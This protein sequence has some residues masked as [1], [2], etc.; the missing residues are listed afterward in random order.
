V[1]IFS[2]ITWH[3]LP[4]NPVNG[5]LGENVTLE[6]NFTLNSA[7]ETLDYF[8]LSRGDDKMIKYSDHTGV[9]WYKSGKGSV[10]LT[11]NGT[12]S[13]TL[14]NLKRSDEKRYCCEVNTKSKWGSEGD[15]EKSCTELLLL[16]KTWGHLSLLHLLRFSFKA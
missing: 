12:S 5:I 2:A 10:G 9:V 13:F 15:F 7:K 4:P 3:K 1:L 16:G 14:I 11:R 6:W 8:E